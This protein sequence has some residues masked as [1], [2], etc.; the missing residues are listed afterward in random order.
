MLTGDPR[1]WRDIGYVRWYDPYAIYEDTSSAE[2]KNAIEE[3]TARWAAAKKPDYTRWFSE[4]KNLLRAALPLSADY[5]HST[6]AWNGLTVKV[7]YGFGHRQHVWILDAESRVVRVHTNL[8]HFGTDPEST[9]YFTIEDVGSG[10]ETLELSVYTLEAEAAAKAAVPLWTMKPVGPGAAFYKD[11]FLY[12]TVENQLRYPGVVSVRKTTGTAHH[13]VYN[14]DD[15]RFQV[16]LIQPIRQSDV[17]IHIG[18]ALQQRIGR[19]VCHAGPASVVWMTPSVAKNAAGEGQTLIPITRNMYGTNDALVIGGRRYMLPKHQYLM[20][21]CCS[22]TPRSIL[23]TTTSNACTSLYEFSIDSQAFRRIVGS[24]GPSDIQLLPGENV[25]C[26]HPA[27]PSVVCTLRNRVL[28]PKLTFPEPVSLPYSHHGYAR[29]NDGTRVPYT[30]VSA[31]QRPIKL[32]VEA[33]GA[34]G[35]NGRQSYPIRWLPWLARGYALAVA[36]PRG[37][38]EH[39]DSWYDGGRTAARKQNTFDDTAAVLHAVQARFHI[40]AERTL[41]YGRSAG[42]LL[43]ANIALQ[44][45]QLVGAVYTEVPYLD[46]L[47]TTTNPALPLTQLEYDEFGDPIR[48]PDEYAALQKISPVDRVSLAPRDAPLVV[49]RTAVHDAQVLPYEALKWAKKMRA[50]DWHIYVG[51]DGNGGHFAA[52]SQLA[53]QYA[54]DAALLDAHIGHRSTTGRA[55]STRR[56]RRHVSKG[57]RRRRTSS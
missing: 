9:L 22:S 57:T 12:Q 17:F 14:A 40:R 28:I 6:D 10:S 20:S 7:Q 37:G 29:S 18:N 46:V 34:Y 50:A 45:P 55:V 43:A 8:T 3:E 27:K 39:G 36:F 41:F 33:Y 19:I 15:K 32:I 25:L 2:F 1:P 38:R 26:M 53:S 52:E 51:I 13:L 5:A 31:I 42:G 23:L 35:I 30:F 24:T 44:F 11:R 49:V 56:V 16:R 47:R 21:A 54:E 48:R 4:Y